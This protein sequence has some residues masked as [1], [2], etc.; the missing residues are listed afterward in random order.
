[1]LITT[2]LTA[3]IS[4]V[5]G[6]HYTASLVPF[7]DSPIIWLAC[8]GL[9]AMAMLNVIGIRESAT[10]ALIME[11]T[12]FFVNLV[13]GVIAVWCFHRRSCGER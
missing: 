12:A 10:V 4:A 5:S 2:I 3:A 6:F 11:L 8:F 9:V 1:M 13:V 7:I